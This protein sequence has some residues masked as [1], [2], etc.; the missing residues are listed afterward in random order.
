[1]TAWP[2]K[3]Q[4]GFLSIYRLKKSVQAIKQISKHLIKKKKVECI[5]TVTCNLMLVF[6]RSSF[7]SPPQKLY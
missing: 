2:S 5:V 4:T 1:M 3:Y 6:I 7:A